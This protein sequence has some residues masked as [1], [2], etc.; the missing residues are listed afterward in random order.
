MKTGKEL[1]HFVSNILPLSG[2]K[3]DKRVMAWWAEQPQAARDKLKP[4]PRP[5]KEVMTKFHDWF[6][7]FDKP[8]LFAAPVSFDCYWGRWYYERFVGNGDNNIFH[9][10]LDMRSI[11][12]ALVGQHSGD[13]KAMIASATGVKIENPIPHYSLFDAREQGE[14]L[15]ALLRWYEKQK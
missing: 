8:I 11:M 15:F 1:S 7:Q 14:Y 9:R 2:T 5:A 13:Y 12:W 6:Y 3:P 10:A 4:N